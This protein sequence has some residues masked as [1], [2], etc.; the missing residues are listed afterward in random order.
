M[1]RYG[2]TTDS[3]LTVPI[4]E[5]GT[6]WSKATGTTSADDTEVTAVAKPAGEDRPPESVMCSGTS[7]SAPA[8]SAGDEDEAGSLWSRTIGTTSADATTAA[9]SV[10]EAMPPE[11]V[12]Y[13][14][15]SESELEESSDEELTLLEQEELRQLR[16]LVR[17]GR[18]VTPFSQ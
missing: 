16:E 8:E 18:P 10:G 6:S 14:A 3:E 11:F 2:A 5:A 9:K 4:G 7:E 15:T 1:A 12:M 17:N 13:C